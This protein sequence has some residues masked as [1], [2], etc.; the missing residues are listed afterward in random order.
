MTFSSG[1]GVAV[2]TGVA[3]ADTIAPATNE[4]VLNLF[5]K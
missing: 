4:F 5:Y 3:N 1:I 2:T